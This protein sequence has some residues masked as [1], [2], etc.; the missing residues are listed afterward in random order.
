MK[1]DPVDTQRPLEFHEANLFVLRANA[2]NADP[3][4]AS[5]L[6]DGDIWYRGDLNVFK[7]KVNGTIQSLSVLPGNIISGTVGATIDVGGTTGGLAVT[8]N[9]ISAVA[10]IPTAGETSIVV[11]YPSVGS[12]FMPLVTIEGTGNP[13]LDGD[14]KALIVHTIGDTSLTIHID[15]L[16]TVQSLRFH[17]L[18]WPIA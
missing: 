14:L 1:F 5:D 8:G 15:E 9:L 13:S 3:L 11:T 16:A 2:L 4:P 18:L 6:K 12:N 10:S 17:V 7:A